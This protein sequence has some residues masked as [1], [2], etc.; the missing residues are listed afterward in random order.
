MKSIF[1]CLLFLA[2]CL[3]PLWGSATFQ[4]IDDHNQLILAALGLVFLIFV[5]AM[6]IPNCRSI[7]IRFIQSDSFRLRWITKYKILWTTICIT[8]LFSIL[9][10][11]VYSMLA[12]VNGLFDQ[13]IQDCQTMQIQEKTTQQ[14]GTVLSKSQ[15]TLDVISLQNPTRVISIDVNDNEYAQASKGRLIKV[16]TK[17][18]NLGAQWIFDYKL[19]Q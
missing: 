3:F 11:E 13:G 10:I 7:L 9:L 6:L 8:S 12:V 15:Y 2:L 17:P 4:V 1:N 19:I 5:C 16:C 14:V 18:G